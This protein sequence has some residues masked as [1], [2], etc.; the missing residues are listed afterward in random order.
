MRRIPV[1][2]AAAIAIVTMAWPG[3]ASAHAILEESTPAPSSVLESSPDEITLDFN[4]AIEDAL[5][6]IRLFDADQ[7]EV[8]TGNATRDDTDTSIARAS[9][10]S[11][12]DGVY[13][14]VW[15]AV[16]ADGHP[17]SGAF[18]F[19]VGDTATV[20]ANE[21]MTRVL[22]GLDTDSPLDAPLAMSRFLSYVGLIVLIGIVV[23]AYGHSPMDPALLVAMRRAVAVFAVGAI[24]IFLLQGPYAAGRGWGAVFDGTLLADVLPTRLGLASLVRLACAAG[25]VVLVVLISRSSTWWWRVGY[26]KVALL[27]VVSFSVSGHPSAG[28]L[29]AVFVSVDVV[30]FVAV[31]VWVGAFFA[32]WLVRA[33]AGVARLSALATVA[34]PIAVATGAVQSVHLAGGISDVFDSRHGSYLLA[35]VMVVAVCLAIGGR[36]RMRMKK[37]QPTVG[38]ML[39]LEAALLVVVI[40]VSSMMVGSSPNTDARS[41]S[42]FSATLIQSDV[43]ADF[44]ILPTR[45]GGA[46]VHVYLT[47]PAGSLS[48]VENVAM[49]FTLPSRGIPAIP[50]TL[51]EIG[52]NHWSGVMQFPYAGTW[53]LESRVQAT[54]NSTLLYTADVVVSD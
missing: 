20:N 1:W 26:A 32:A 43:V 8:S 39:S 10:S 49:S 54:K 21:L 14:V 12:D 50:V 30:H 31:S 19:Q 9:V 24:G 2:C 46:E 22:N 44:S 27:S 33:E 38:R 4:E 18:P 25:W 52:P 6:S 42:A 36:L 51:I 41:G 45:V 23:F 7:R 17:V 34:M 5:L 11:L 47:P 28:S 35:K 48:P 53:T 37:S 40:A 16:S 29:S 15:R 13:V 3:A